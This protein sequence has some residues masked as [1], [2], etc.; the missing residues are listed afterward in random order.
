MERPGNGTEDSKKR[1]GDR[2]EHTHAK[3]P[4]TAPGDRYREEQTHAKPPPTAPGDRDAPPRG[5]KGGGAQI[6]AGTSGGADQGSA[7]DPANDSAGPGCQRGRVQSTMG[8]G[9]PGVSSNP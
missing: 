8:L 2:E 1:R 5:G 7:Q 6:V 9:G 3:P 4:P